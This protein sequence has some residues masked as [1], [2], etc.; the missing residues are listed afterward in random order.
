MRWLRVAS[1][2]DKY[3]GHKGRN[4]IVDEEL[5]SRNLT[6]LKGATDDAN[7]NFENGGNESDSGNSELATLISHS[8]VARSS[9]TPRM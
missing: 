1:A 3:T 7:L 6:F 2:A 8:R 9:V 4:L 5:L